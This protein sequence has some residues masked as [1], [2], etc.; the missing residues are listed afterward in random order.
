MCVVLVHKSRRNSTSGQKFDARFL[1]ITP[2][3]PL[4]E[5]ILLLFRDNEGHFCTELMGLGVN[6]F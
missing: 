3:F 1:F 4:K 5:Q 2:S 6:R